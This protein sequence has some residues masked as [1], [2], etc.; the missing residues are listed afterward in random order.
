MQFCQQ[1]FEEVVV[2]VGEGDVDFAAG[3][4]VPDAVAEEEAVRCK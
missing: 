3:G 2:C 1:G 4:L